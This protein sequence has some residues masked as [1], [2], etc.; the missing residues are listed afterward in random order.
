MSATE[1]VLIPWTPTSV[2]KRDSW[3]KLLQLWVR[4]RRT[5]IDTDGG[6]KQHEIIDTKWV[7]V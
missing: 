7:K 3:G 1:V 4:E 6:I 2:L 5:E